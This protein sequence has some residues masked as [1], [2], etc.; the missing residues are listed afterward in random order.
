MRR[1]SAAWASTAPAR[2][3]WRTSIRSVASAS[4]R[5]PTLAWMAAW[6]PN[7]IAR[8]VNVQIGQK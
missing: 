6:M 4:R 1:S 3:S 5:R 8:A 2:V 7:A